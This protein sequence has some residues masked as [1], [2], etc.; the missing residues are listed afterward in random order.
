MKTR[1][2][3]AIVLLAAALNAKADFITFHYDLLVTQAQSDAQFQVGDR[4]RGSIRFDTAIPFAFDP[5]FPWG[6]SVHFAVIENSPEGDRVSFFDDLDLLIAGITLFDPSGRTLSNQEWN[7][8]LFNP[9]R[10]PSGRFAVTA[11]M[12]NSTLN[13][14]GIITNVSDTGSTGLLLLVVCLSFIALRRL[15]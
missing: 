15:A 10:W 4:P 9:Q 12:E 1:T 14:R 7:P 13:F 2:L 5:S 11:M 6:T 3:I 8:D